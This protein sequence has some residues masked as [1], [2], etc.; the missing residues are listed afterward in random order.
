M[1]MMDWE[2][3]VDTKGR[4]KE[5]AMEAKENGLLRVCGRWRS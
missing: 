2:N 4:G 3:W 5:L 1:K